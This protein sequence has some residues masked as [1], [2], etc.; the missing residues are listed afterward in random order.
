[1]TLRNEAT[2]AWIIPRAVVIDAGRDH[3]EQMFADGGMVEDER[4]H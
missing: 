3:L 2:G 4:G 1:M